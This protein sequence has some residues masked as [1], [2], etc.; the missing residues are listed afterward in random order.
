MLADVDHR[1]RLA[2]GAGHHHM[3]RSKR[4]KDPP[5]MQLVW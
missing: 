1:A 5:D 4:Q 3:R 2:L